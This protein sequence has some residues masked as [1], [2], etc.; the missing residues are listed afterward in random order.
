MRANAHV[1]VRDRPAAVGRVWSGSVC[2]CVRVTVRVCA[3]VRVRVHVSGL[4][5]GADVCRCVKLSG[6]V[7]SC[8]E[9]ST[10]LSWRS[11]AFGFGSRVGGGVESEL[12]V[13]VEVG[14][15]IGF[16]FRRG[17]LALAVDSEYSESKSELE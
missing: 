7:S 4:G 10:R 14:N 11:V 3:A 13:G 12:E 9:L 5:V 1:H 17:A 2:V 8:L 6:V 15:R 16:A